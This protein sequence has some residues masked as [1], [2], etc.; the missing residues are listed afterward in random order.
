M[1]F[2]TKNL[3]F[4]PKLNFQR[5]VKSQFWGENSKFFDFSNFSEYSKIEIFCQIVMKNSSSMKCKLSLKLN[6]WTKYWGLEQCADLICFF[7]TYSRKRP[8]SHS[9]PLRSPEPI[10]KK[11]CSRPTP[12]ASPARG[13]RAPANSTPNGVTNGHSNGNR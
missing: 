4:N 10:A 6:F 3:D 11:H 1:N 2:R 8:H 13:R 12:P 7:S 9:P 5:I